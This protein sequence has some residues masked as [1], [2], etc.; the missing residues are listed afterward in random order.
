MARRALG[1]DAL[2][3]QREY[4]DE[5][6]VSYF[7]HWLLSHL[8]PCSCTYPVEHGL[9]HA[10]HVPARAEGLFLPARALHH[11]Q[12][13]L[14]VA[15]AHTHTTHN[16]GKACDEIGHLAADSIGLNP[17]ACPPLRTHVRT[18]GSAAHSRSTPSSARTMGRFS[19]FRAR[20][21]LSVMVPTPPS[22]E[23]AANT[24]GCCGGGAPA[25]DVAAALL[26]LEE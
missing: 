13:H 17:H 1:G 9:P 2:F 8:L 3:E 21:R 25:A 4:W 6:V 24:S 20:G 22:G 23:T 26:L 19:A 15:R 10:H 7:P 11:H 5:H 14:F 12:L 16:K 18:L